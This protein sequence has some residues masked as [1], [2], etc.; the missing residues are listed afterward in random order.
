MKYFKVILLSGITLSYLGCSSS[1]GDDPSSLLTVDLGKSSGIIIPA[2]ANTLSCEQ[3]AKGDLTTGAISGAYFTLPNPRISWTNPAD[4][5][6]AS[7]TS[8]LRVVVLK[9]T[10]KSPKIG[11][12]YSCIFSDV[13]LGSLF[14][15]KTTQTN[16]NVLVNTWDG[17][18]SR[19]S[20]NLKNSTSDLIGTGGAFTPCD[21]KCGG[22]SIPKGTSQFSVTGEYELLAV[23]KKFKTADAA[24]SST[25]YEEFPIKVVGSFTVDYTLN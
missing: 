1:K 16:G 20:T 14:Y 3:I 23:Q 22:M 11:G 5:V 10:L 9:L 2:P 21:I 25:D 4:A 8:E 24:A 17:R 6:V 13:A 7:S 15:A 19:N 12:E 18:L